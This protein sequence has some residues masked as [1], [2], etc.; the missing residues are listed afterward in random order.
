MQ[1]DLWGNLLV[2]GR[3]S[4]PKPQA[5]KPAKRKRRAKLGQSWALRIM[6]NF[7]NAF[8]A[9]AH[10]VGA[11]L[12]AVS[13]I[14]FFVSLAGDDTLA[15]IVSGG[16]A[17]VFSLGEVALWD[18]GIAHAIRWYKGVALFLA[19][20]TAVSMVWLSIPELVASAEEVKIEETLQ[21]ENAAAAKLR[22]DAARATIE[23]LSTLPDDYGQSKREIVSALSELVSVDA[24]S[25]SSKELKAIEKSPLLS[26]GGFW[27]A[28]GFLSVRAIAL[29]FVVLGTAPKPKKKPVVKPGKGKRK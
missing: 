21:A 13:D 16:L 15:K 26:L 12:M 1:R 7:S 17:V 5:P 11:A 23:A 8:F 9:L 24:G 14:M 4:S 19:V 28:V 18:R 10:I 2:P 22:E 27:I 6:G 3:I 25:G 20:F 29:Q